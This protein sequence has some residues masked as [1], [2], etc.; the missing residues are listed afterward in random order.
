MED[1]PKDGV[2]GFEFL[3][4][5]DGEIREVGVLH[6]HCKAGTLGLALDRQ[7]L[8]I[9]LAEFRV[10]VVTEMARLDGD[11]GVGA[12]LEGGRGFEV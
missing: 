2:F 10:H 7:L 12:V 6:I 1:G 5:A 8:D 9:V 4:E 11:G 3:V